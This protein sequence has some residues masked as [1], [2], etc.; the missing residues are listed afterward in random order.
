MPN[1]HVTIEKTKKRYKLQMMLAML[2][3]CI[4]AALVIVGFDPK[5]PEGTASSTTM[6]GVYTA[7]AGF[8]W[9]AVAK[10]LAWWNHG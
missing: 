6:G 8:V 2:L 5:A 7:V 4:G 10:G 1:D 3:F 9:Y